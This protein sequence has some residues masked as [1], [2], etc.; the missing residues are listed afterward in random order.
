MSYRKKIS[1]IM[2]SITATSIIFSCDSY[3]YGA[4]SESTERS[5]LTF[6]VVKNKVIKNQTT[7]DE[8]VKLLVHQI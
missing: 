3:K 1:L 6:G 4:N 2:L 7:Q 8:I 5:N